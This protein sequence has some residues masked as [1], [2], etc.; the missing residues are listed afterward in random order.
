MKTKVYRD[1]VSYPK[2]QRIKTKKLRLEDKTLTPKYFL[3]NT[4]LCFLV[5]SILNISWLLDSV[6]FIEQTSKS[7]ITTSIQLELELQVRAIGK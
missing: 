6:F 2:L 5:L 3:L 1:L 7:T 4:T